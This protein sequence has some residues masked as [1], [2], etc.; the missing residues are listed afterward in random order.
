MIVP[1]AVEGKASGSGE[2]REGL[3][4]FDWRLRTADWQDLPGGMRLSLRRASRGDAVHWTR[5]RQ[6][7]AVGAGGINRQ[8]DGYGIFRFIERVTDLPGRVTID[9]RLFT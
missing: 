1:P 4:I 5:I 2:Q 3:G 6:D 9:G 7:N 8:M